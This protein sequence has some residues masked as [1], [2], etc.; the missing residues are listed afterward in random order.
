METLSYGLWLLIAITIGYF[1]VSID[2]FRH[3]NIP[4]G[5]V[6]GG[7]AFANIGLIWSIK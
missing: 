3:G 4:M 5:M 7:Y 2:L 1:I 6:F